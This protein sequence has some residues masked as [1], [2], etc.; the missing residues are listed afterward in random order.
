MTT[1][2]TASQHCTEAAASTI[3]PGK[4]MKYKVEKRDFL[5]LILIL[6]VNILHTNLLFPPPSLLSLVPFLLRFKGLVEFL[7]KTVWVWN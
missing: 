6:E 3:I 5:Q 7:V 4:E 2:S 1:N